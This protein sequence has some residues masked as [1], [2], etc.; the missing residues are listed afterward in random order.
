MSRFNEVNQF[1]NHDVLQ[2]LNWFLRKFRVQPNTTR[3][4]I[5]RTPLGLHALHTPELGFHAD[6]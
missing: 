1:V 2:T 6:L 4:V 3:L 5:T